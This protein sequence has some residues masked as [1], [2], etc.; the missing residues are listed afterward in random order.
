MEYRTYNKKKLDY[1]LKPDLI[2]N[3]LQKTLYKNK[4]IINLSN[5]FSFVLLIL[6]VLPYLIICFF[7]SIL[8]AYKIIRKLQLLW[9]RMWLL[10][11]GIYYK[12]WEHKSFN[13]NENVIFMAEHFSIH[14]IPLYGLTWPEHTYALSAKEYESVPIYGWTL[15]T[16]GAVFLERRDREKA[17]KD[18]ELIKQRMQKENLSLLVVPT[19]TRAKDAVLL[20]FKKGVFHLSISLRKP[21]VP[22]YLIGLENLITSKLFVKPGKVDVV[23]G[24]PIRPEIYPE[25][26]DD[27]EK[28]KNLVY[29]K[30]SNEGALLREKRND[31]LN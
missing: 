29:Q 15:K 11:F 17:I 3:L 31:Y 26:F 8:S 5:Y 6:V 4:K 22:V 16:T 10:L 27:L 25:E 14:D 18:L 9:G 24:E 1:L 12:S 19:G 20:P 7:L 2:S 13:K 30:M 23:Y 21:I 28:L